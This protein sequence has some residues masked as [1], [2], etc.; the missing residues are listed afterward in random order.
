MS[1]DLTWWRNA[2]A[3]NVA[4]IDVNTPCRGW[5]RARR[6]GQPY[7]PVAYWWEG[8]AQEQ[9]VCLYD[10]ELID[11]HIAR[12]RWPFV[13]KNPVPY[14]VYR[15]V[16]EEGGEWPDIDSVAAEQLRGKGDNNPPSDPAELLKEQ[17]ESASAGADAYAT[18]ADDATAAKAQTLRSR[19]LELSG[20]ADT[21]REKLKAPHWEAAKAV[22]AKWQ[23]LVKNAKAVAD[24]IRAALS[25][26]ETAKMRKAAAE[27]AKAQ[28]EAQKA[29]DAGKPVPPPPPPVAPSGPIKGAAGR[30]ASVKKRRVVT[31]I[32]NLD[33]VFMCVKNRPEVAALF[34]KI[35]QEI[36][37]NNQDVLG[38]VIETVAD[39]R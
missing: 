5:Y 17:I 8:D 4:A 7:R 13:S 10:G 33:A 38:V 24:K 11:E 35:A 14:E 31:S 26:W 16:A 15:L 30:A 36:V 18:I 23:P 32:S 22:D 21:Q 27:Q 9:L 29:I 3:G 25:E 1:N 37:D 20:E 2:L 12:E 39:V 34:M 6:K 19:L 28:A